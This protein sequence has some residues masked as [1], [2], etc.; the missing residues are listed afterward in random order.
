MQPRL[1]FQADLL[2]LIRIWKTTG[3]GIILLGDFNKNV[4]EGKYALDLLG[5]KF[6]MSALCLRTTGSRLPNAHI[7]GNVPIDAVFAT[8]EIYSTAV[9]LLPHRVGV[10]D[11][12]VFLL[13]IDSNTLLG[14]IFPC[15]IPVAR[16]LLNCASDWIKENYILVL[17]RLLNRHWIFTKLLYIDRE[18][19]RIIQAQ[20]QLQM[21]KVD[22]E[23]EEIMKSSEKRCHKFKQDIIK[24]SPY[25]KV[26]IHWHWLLKR[27]EQ[28]LE[29][30]TRD[31]QNL[32]CKC[33]RG[34]VKSPLQIKN[35]RTQDQVFCVQEE[36]R[37]PYEK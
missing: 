26:W 15:V 37:A 12:G 14:D 3:D 29:G 35:G 17:N 18:S 25:V 21:N 32:I 1:I 36:Y 2:N 7:R 4:Y 5:N 28:Y 24:W 11:H 6:R 19:D 33:H 22:L 13:D 16:R 10:G 27:V 34:G 23:L 8:A 30:M 31:P 9:T 20:L